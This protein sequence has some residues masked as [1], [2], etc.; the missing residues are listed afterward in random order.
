MSKRLENLRAKV[1]A[2]ESALQGKKGKEKKALQ[3]QLKEA[4]EKLK[5]LEETERIAAQNIEEAK[6]RAEAERNEQEVLAQEEIT[7]RRE[8]KLAQ[9]CDGDYSW[10]GELAFDEHGRLLPNLNNT[11]TIIEHH[12]EWGETIRKNE[13]TGAIEWNGSPI[14]DMDEIQIYFK[15]YD[16]TGVDNKQWVRDSIVECAR[17]HCYHPIL[18]KVDALEWDGE[19][20]LQD[21]FI[22]TVGAEDTPVTREAS[23]RWL[24]AMYR[25]VKHPGCYF[26]AYIILTDPTQG[27]GKTKIFEKLTE[28]LD[29]KNGRGLVINYTAINAT[30]TYNDKDNAMIINNSVVTTFDEGSDMKYSKLEKFKS[31]IS[32]NT[33]TLRIPYEQHTKTFG[34]HTVFSVTTNDEKFLTDTTSNYERRAWVLKCHGDPNRS[35]EE[36]AKLIP[37]EYIQQMWAEAKWWNDNAEEAEKRHGWKIVDG[38][39]SALTSSGREKMEELQEQSKTYDDDVVVGVA[40]EQIFNQTYTQKEFATAEAFMGDHDRKWG[41]EATNYNFAIDAV[42]VKWVAAYVNRLTK[43]QSRSLRYINTVIESKSMADV[44]GVWEKLEKVWYNKQQLT[45]WVRKTPKNNPEKP[46]KNSVFSAKKPQK[47]GVFLSQKLDEKSGFGS[48][49]DGGIDAQEPFDIDL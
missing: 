28:G 32:Q 34:V 46:Q 20:R 19:E 1:E 25:R 44:I 29:I 11:R 12:K 37:K 9:I 47:N 14:T 38:S 49:F 22:R 39:I 18:E 48:D 33:C 41:E 6:Q 2:L 35:P 5:V 8:E 13:F 21:F 16:L 40:L 15:I 27:T 31:F 24:C 23:F 7:F 36:W 42:P 4:E 26:D 43:G 17:K 30:P 3:K 10:A 45:C